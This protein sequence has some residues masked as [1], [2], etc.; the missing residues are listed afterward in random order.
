MGPCEQVYFFFALM[1]IE[2]LVVYATQAT[3]HPD[4]SPKAWVPFQKNMLGLQCAFAY[5]RVIYYAAFF[6]G[7]E[8]DGLD[9]LWIV[10]AFQ[11]VLSA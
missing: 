9:G 11:Q 8:R 6:C 3:R 10:R 7:R 4:G 1:Q 2:V 5:S